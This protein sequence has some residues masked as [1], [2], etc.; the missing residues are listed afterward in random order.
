MIIRKMVAMITEND[1]ELGRK[2]LH[3]ALIL[4]ALYLI[5]AFCQFLRSYL[6]HYAAWHFVSD[7]RV[8]VYNHLQK[9]SLRYYHD[10]QTGQ[11][12]SRTSNDT[13][14][15]ENLI[16]HSTPD[17]IVNVLLLIGVTI[18]LFSIN[19]VLAF[20]S[21]ITV[22]FIVIAA[23]YFA[24]RVLPQFKSSQQAF[25]EFNAAL[26]DNLQGIKEIQ[27]FN[28]EEKENKKIHEKSKVHVKTLLRVLKLSAIYHPTIEFFSNM[29][30]VIVIGFGGYLASLGRVPLEDII[31]FILYL[32]MFY[33][34]ISSSTLLF[35]G[36][37][38]IWDISV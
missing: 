30:V 10:K 16:A 7:M 21:L 28:Q 11:L 9:L 33:H 20:L 29:G 15:L 22:P 2:A 1:P 25:A 23:A 17:L 32:N 3:S 36:W 5:Q 13:S 18:I 24:K 6:T 27:I 8:R 38:G 31:T 34:P 37:S 14:T 4:G 19:A 12:M 35:E 26:H